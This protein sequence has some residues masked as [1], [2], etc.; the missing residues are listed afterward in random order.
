MVVNA[1]MQLTCR[2]KNLSEFL[3]LSPCISGLCFEYQ[4]CHEFCDLGAHQFSALLA[5]RMKSY[6]PTIAAR[7]AEKQPGQRSKY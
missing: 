7:S 1:S 4:C 2:C 5:Y 6:E 3:S